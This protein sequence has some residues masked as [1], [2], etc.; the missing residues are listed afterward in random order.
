M[1][2]KN[3][4]RNFTPFSLFRRKVKHSSNFICT[5]ARTMRFA[6]RCLSSLTTINDVTMSIQFPAGKSQS[7][8]PICDVSFREYQFPSVLKRKLIF[9]KQKNESA[10]LIKNKF[11]V[12]RM[13]RSRYYTTLVF[14][15]CFGNY[16]TSC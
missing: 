8:L 9:F 4:L 11:H 16:G 1:Q 3:K 13:T 2:T 5:F 7:S 10:V 12:K 14:P 6:V 15:S